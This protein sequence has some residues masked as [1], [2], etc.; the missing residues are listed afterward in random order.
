MYIYIYILYIYIYIYVCVY[1]YKCIRNRGRV[2]CLQDELALG[3][4]VLDRLDRDVFPLGEFEDVLL[5]VDD[6]QRPAV[7]DP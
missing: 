2:T 5:A 6:A 3:H 4:N 1:I 7:V